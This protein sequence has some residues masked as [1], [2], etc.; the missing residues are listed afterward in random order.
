MPSNVTGRRADRNRRIGALAG[1]VAVIASLAVVANAAKTP[2]QLSQAC[3]AR[4]ADQAKSALTKNLTALDG[5]HRSR[6][7][8]KR[9]DDCNVLPFTAEKLAAKVQ[10]KCPAGEPVLAN[11][12]GGDPAAR[13]TAVFEDEVHASGVALQGGAALTGDKQA[14]KCRD[15]IGKARSKIVKEVVAAAVKCQK[16]I[17]KSASQFGPL[18]PSCRTTP[19]DKAVA[20]AAKSITKACQRKVAPKTFTPITGAS[21]GSCDPLPGC[22]ASAAAATAAT[23]AGT[24]YKTPAVCGD[25]AVDVG[26]ACDLGADVATDCCSAACELTTAGVTCRTAAGVCD[27]AETCTGT[28]ALCPFDQKRIDECGPAPDPCDPPAVCDGASNECP[29]REQAV[30]KRM[31]AA[32]PER[33]KFVSQTFAPLRKET[34][35]QFGALVK[36]TKPAA[37]N[38]PAP[39]VS[40][41]NSSIVA[42]G[43]RQ[44]G[45]VRKTVF[46]GNAGA[47]GTEPELD[48]LWIVAGP[49]SGECSDV[50]SLRLPDGDEDIDLEAEFADD[51]GSSE[52]TIQFALGD[53]EQPLTE[54]QSVTLQPSGGFFR[55][56]RDINDGAGGSAPRAFTNVDGTV[57]FVAE[58][59]ENVSRIWRSNG[60]EAG[61]VA[62]PFG[63]IP[64]PNG[65]LSHRDLTAVGTKLYFNRCP[66][67]ARCDLFETDGAVTTLVQENVMTSCSTSNTSA[68]VGAGL[69]RD[70]LFFVSDPR[71]ES[72]NPGCELWRSGPDGMTTTVTTTMVRDIRTGEAGSNPRE[73]TAFEAGVLFFADDGTGAQVWRSDGTFE[74][75]LAASALDDN[76][77]LSELV[78]S[79][80]AFYFVANQNSIYRGTATDAPT[81]V[82]PSEDPFFES[83]SELTDVAG[84]LYFKGCRSVQGSCELW[85]IAAGTPVLVRDIHPNG[86]SNPSDLTAVGDLLFFRATDGATGNEIWRSDGTENGTFLVLDIEPGSANSEPRSLTAVGGTLVFTA[87][88]S[89]RGRELWQSDG[90]AAGTDRIR[91]LS[92]GKG[93]GL[94]LD[95]RIV[96][97]GSVGYFA[98]AAENKGAEPY[99]VKPFESAPS[100]QPTPTPTAVAPVPTATL[101]PAPGSC[102]VGRGGDFAPACD[103][104]GCAACVCGADPYC[105]TT[106]WDEL[107]ATQAAEQCRDQCPCVTPTP[108]PTATP[109]SRDCC[110]PHAEPACEVEACSLCVCETDPFCCANQWDDICAREASG[111]LPNCADECVACI[112]P[113]PTETPTPAP[114]PTPLLGSCCESHDTP[115][116]DVSAC[117]SCVCDG[118]PYCCEQQWDSVCVGEASGG[119]PGCNE[120]CQA[121]SA[122]PTPSPTPT[123][124]P[125]ATPVVSNCCFAH[126]EAGCDVPECQACIC[127]FDGFCCGQFWDPVCADEANGALEA[128]AGDC[129]VCTAAP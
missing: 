56:A 32:Q 110:V 113:T 42:G 11:Y 55:R 30:A 4:I 35:P 53:A 92:A 61:T 68:P 33:G 115:G 72:M 73:L 8:G 108:A 87:N 2:A 70:T 47:R 85:R 93:L 77:S 43:G 59:I 100:P 104:T 111:E 124:V 119:F 75:T 7:Q 129:S 6:D 107:C 41:R 86:S 114:T 22:V 13:I 63:P 65:I 67:S 83:V 98:A 26:E 18:A 60:S 28:S 127:A 52:L 71:A 9:A 102:C 99:A 89:T 31:R 21:V 25:G 69:A 1:V 45:I 76:P 46:G 66:S 37:G 90:T 125:T 128:C 84:S 122:P 44:F 96:A 62:V 94:D 88:D 29:T 14:G 123:P 116:C 24:I 79:G 54:Y 38:R 81:E 17:D 80:D 78:V 50:F 91:D 64:T 57:F 97:A 117:A 40:V 58:A 27:L 82:A 23:L 34:T 74:G 126:G 103:T 51:L 10:E 12:G 121:C 16:A 106:N 39:A 15:A 48:Y 5:C 3:R 120:A 109:A 95:T 36:T 19:S 101:T 112:A 20:S 105:C 49:E 118:D